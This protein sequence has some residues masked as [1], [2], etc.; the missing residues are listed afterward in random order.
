MPLTLLL[1]AA[2]SR[3]AAGGDSEVAEL[4]VA[5]SIAA[6]SPDVDD[7]GDGLA[8]VDGDCDDTSASIHPGAIEVCGDGAD[9]DC[10]GHADGGD[11]TCPLAGAV[12]ADDA[13]AWAEGGPLLAA[14][15]DG[16]GAA[17]GLLQTG[18]GA[19][20]LLHADGTTQ[21]FASPTS[22]FRGV[23]GDLD[24]DGIP[25]LW[26]DIEG[27][28]AFLR[29]GPAESWSDGANL[30]D[31]A[32]QG[33]W[34]GA[35]LGVPDL[36]GDGRDEL[37]VSS[38]CCDGAIYF[39]PGTSSG[40]VWAETAAYATIRP[41]T[42]NGS[43]DSGEFGKRLETEDL[44]GDGVDELV[45]LDTLWPSVGG[46][47]Q[48]GRVLVFDLPVGGGE[49]R[50]SDATAEL[51]GAPSPTMLDVVAPG[52]TDGDGYGDLA[53]GWGGVGWTPRLLSVVSGP[54]RG[55][56]DAAD[57]WAA[58]TT[59]VEGTE[60]H[61]LERGAIAFADDWDGDGRI[62][63]ALT[64]SQQS[65]DD[66]ELAGVVMAGL[67]AGAY[68]TDDAVLWVSAVDRDIVSLAGMAE[69]DGHRALFLADANTSPDAIGG[70]TWGGYELLT[71]R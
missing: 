14:D 40:A 38:A 59:T 1:L 52:D 3:S 61:F 39:L 35:I 57:A 66:G 5:T 67:D 36:D 68:T 2:C 10:D 58:A 56:Y 15:F 29:S 43:L 41:W 63:Y 71:Q 44:D 30:L 45:V 27:G 34:T 64:N 65:L 60:A 46:Y 55:T 70:D 22:I 51:D 8:E 50:L 7:D 25:E 24:G 42:D 19:Y 62:D 28:G 17:E 4:P 9:D 48:Y 31:I 18:E 11:A 47:E 53:F 16:D 23:A 33:C 54:F 20:A 6:G 69:L 37:A 21:T 12:T 13:D 26:G 32:F 49:R